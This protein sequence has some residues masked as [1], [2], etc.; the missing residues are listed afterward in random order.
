MAGV[1]D[2]AGNLRRAIVAYSEALRYY[3]PD[4]SPLKYAMAQANLGIAYKELGD[5]QAAV[6]CWREAEK[7]FRQMDMV[8]DAARMLEWIKDAEL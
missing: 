6:A 8:E 7:Y 2:R 5:R 1:E 4:V 3:T